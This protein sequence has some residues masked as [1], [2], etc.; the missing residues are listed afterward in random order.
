MRVYILEHQ[1]VLQLLGVLLCEAESK[2]SFST[3][4]SE[5]LDE[6][7]L[8]VAIA[9]APICLKTLQM[10]TPTSVSQVFFLIIDAGKVSQ[11]RCENV[12]Q[13][14]MDKFQPSSL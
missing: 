11:K 1:R 5:E 12:S 10:L 9:K 8:V 13:K 4:E 2:R 7:E 3:F 6:E 14:F